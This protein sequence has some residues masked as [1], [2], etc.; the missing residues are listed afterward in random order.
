MPFVQVIP[1]EVSSL[2]PSNRL[3]QAFQECI[4]TQLLGNF[5]TGNRL[6]ISALLTSLVIEKAF[7]EGFLDRLLQK[8]YQPISARFPDW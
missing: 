8:R 3:L 5:W 6:L 2:L 4:P 7:T 1:I